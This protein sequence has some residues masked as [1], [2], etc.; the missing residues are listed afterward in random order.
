MGFYFN[1]APTLL[2][3]INLMFHG[4]SEDGFGLTFLPYLMEV[5]PANRSALY[6]PL[7]LAN[8]PSLAGDTLIIA[9][10]ESRGNRVE[11]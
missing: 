11:T 2:D 10:D 5:S 4:A 6:V 1:D 3:Q 9:Y 7:C 8:L